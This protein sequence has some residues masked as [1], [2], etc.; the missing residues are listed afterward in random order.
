MS[1]GIVHTICHSY[2]VKRQQTLK[3]LHGHNLNRFYRQKSTVHLVNMSCF[4]LTAVIYNTGRMNNQSLC[5][6]RQRVII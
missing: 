6:I 3:M 1:L 2:T 5:Q 4:A